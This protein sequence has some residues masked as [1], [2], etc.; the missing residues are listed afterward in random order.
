[1]KV[2]RTIYLAI[3][4]VIFAALPAMAEVVTF[5][6]GA[7]HQL[8]GIYTEVAVYDTAENQPTRV[9]LITGGVVSNA[10]T[11]WQTSSAVI[12]GGT[13]AGDLATY[14]TASLAITG[15][16][17]ARLWPVHYSTVD[18]SGGLVLYSMAFHSSVVDMSGGE[19][20]FLETKQGSR[21]NVS[22]GDIGEICAWDS[23][24]IT[25]HGYDFVTTDGLSLSGDQVLG[26]SGTLGGK[27]LDGTPWTMR[28]LRRD[29]GTTISTTISPEPT[30]LGLFVLG[31]SAMLMRRQG[32]A[33]ATS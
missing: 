27:W 32:K 17:V 2:P 18:I 3:A 15:G 26:R 6:D 4:F 25:L 28:I 23:S 14:D 7:Y 8:N 29:V 16:Y 19:I 1:M 13:V 21:V 22:G 12:S 5:E 33:S 24:I 9:E 20:S 10:L 31:G 30:T 11:V